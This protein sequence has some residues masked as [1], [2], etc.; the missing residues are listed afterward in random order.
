MK[1]LIKLRYLF[2]GTLKF[3]LTMRLTTLLLII[4]LF[5]IQANTYSQKVKISLDLDGV[6]VERV[7]DE[8]ENLSDFKFLVNTNEV[9]LDRIISIK[10]K[11]QRI[12]AILT[13][14]FAGTDVTYKVLDKQI[15][16]KLQP[17]VIV[18]PEPIIEEEEIIQNQVSGV[19]TDKDGTPL[20]GVNIIIVGTTRGVS[21]DF[22]GNYTIEANVGDVLEF[23][24]IGMLTDRVTVGDSNTI[25][26][27]MQDGSSSLD[28]VVITALGIKRE[29]RAV[30]Y[31]VTEIDGAELAQAAQ[32]N[33][34]NSLQGKTAGVQVSSTAGGTFGGARITIRGNSS[35]NQ[36]TQPIFV[37]D[38]VVLDNEISGGSDWGNQLKNLNPDDFETFSIL[39]GAAASALYGSRALN[40]VVLITTK[41]G[42]KQKGLGVSF[43]QTTGIR[44]VY[45]T[46]DFQNE[47]GSGPTVGGFSGVGP[48][49][50]SIR[51]ADVLD[52]NQPYLT[53]RATGI[54]SVEGTGGEERAASWGPR[55]D[56]R[57]YVD[58]DGSI[59]QWNSQPNNIK[60][61]YDTGV[62]TN[63]NVAISGGGE[64][65]AFR[66]SLS[67]MSETGVNPRND[68][69]K[70]SMSMNG[71][72][73]LIKDKLTIGATIH[74]TRALAENPVNGSANSQWMHDGFPR[75]YDTNKWRNNYKDVDGGIPY[76]FGNS[77]NLT[78]YAKRWM[79]AYDD[80]NERVESSLISKIDIDLNIAKGVDLKL[81]ANVNQYNIN[82]TATNIS[83]SADR[84]NGS[85]SIG[86]SEKFQHSLSAKMFFDKEI[87]ED[88]QMDLVLGGEMWSTESEFSNSSTSGG[89]KIRDFYNISNSKNAASASGGIGAVKKINSLYAFYN[90]SYKRDLY[91]SIT[92]RNDWSSALVYP[93]GHGTKS[94][95]YPS[96]SLGWVTSETFELPQFIS[97]AKIR[98][99]Y[100]VVGND[101]DPYKLSTGFVVDRFNAQPD[102]N[103][104]RYENGQA[105]STTLL[106]E[107]KYSFEAGFD[108]RMFNNRVKFD[109]TYYKDNNK[110]QI[111]GLPVP[112][113]SGISSQL[114]NAGNL[115]NQ[116][117][118]VALDFKIIQNDDWDW[119]IGINGTRNR[120][121][122]ISLAPGINE[123]YL[124]GDPGNANSSTGTFAYVGG[125]YG[126][127]ATYRG[128]KYY[129]GSNTANLGEKVLENRNNW[130][131]A[132][133]SGF[134]N[135]DSLQVMGN[136]QADWYGGANT[137]LRYKNFQLSALVDARFGGE[138]YSADLRYG[139]HQGVIQSS[140]AN[141]D[142]E[143]GAISWVSQGM[144][145]NQFGKTYTDG[146]IPEG[147][148]PDGTN[149]TSKDASGNST[150]VNVGGMKYSDAYAQ[151]LVE[152]THY[153]GFVYR[154]T[155]A[156]TGN[157]ITGIFTQKWIGL[158]EVTLAYNVPNALLDKTFI[159]RASVALTGRDLGFLYNSA[160][161]NVNPI[162]SSNA[163]ANPLQMSSAPYVRSITL[164]LKL[165][166]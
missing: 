119:S 44:S 152:P 35:F 26:F 141:R 24:F 78:N 112:Q 105:V 3:N 116:G 46:V 13:K 128:Y 157:P 27:A 98:A 97:F 153:S 99:S 70:N 29:A 2:D 138:M 50:N 89:L 164:A 43:S 134:R 145:Q 95:F 120:D 7:L 12:S 68:F 122:I 14:I 104:F 80:T 160:P 94:Y 81:E 21:T 86:H 83:N 166:F 40:G 136:M 126:D 57:D 54:L 23:S 127:L 88:I 144:G 142:P 11:K 67:S 111:I 82:S 62:L 8:I 100:A 143:H 113:E 9:N 147:V 162:I 140:V 73:D 71:S 25:N 17:R 161:D 101:T 49:A 66:L 121:K 149:I 20:P 51:R 39:K 75:S 125:N 130:S 30:G 59:A 109:F 56:G 10:E 36:N 91:L 107:K 108:L 33:P 118:E 85:Y 117:V 92:A 93:D 133:A 18:E 41:K 69:A 16:L 5:K 151:G 22:D 129:E 64:T 15:V 155:S 72:Q 42:S 38:G 53:D 58:Y 132:Y 34:V 45:N 77:Y 55:F 115:Q 150:T 65:N 19:V 103:M 123:F 165:N 79:D 163:A 102:L 139:M 74:Y 37:V 32:L 154:H 76:P 28:E 90:V 84:L 156:S 61:W 124:F 47:Y 60:D 1:K 6:S 31:S 159:N 4:S 158:R 87:N 148:F 63:T 146:Y 131:V 106:P 137:S 135:R 110:N 96:V 48:S 114:I 52:N